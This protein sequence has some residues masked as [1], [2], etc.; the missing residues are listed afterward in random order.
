[1]NTTEI[2]EI[3]ARLNYLE[4]FVEQIQEERK[5]AIMAKQRLMLVIFL[6]ALVGAFIAALVG[7]VWFHRHGGL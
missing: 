2:N 4:A 5:Q 6:V 1:M 3:L 7:L